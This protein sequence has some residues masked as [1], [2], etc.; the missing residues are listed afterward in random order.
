MDANGGAIPYGEGKEAVTTGRGTPKSQAEA[1]RIAADVL[2]SA[3]ETNAGT[4][5]NH[6]ADAL[7]EPHAG[8]WTCSVHLSFGL[9]WNVPK[10]GSVSLAR[11]PVNSYVKVLRQSRTHLGLITK[12]R[13]TRSGWRYDLIDDDGIELWNIPEN[14]VHTLEPYRY[15]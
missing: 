9:Q 12:A 5:L 3:G 11:Y 4:T 10:D 15:G 14:S 8:E 2:H 1:Y 13:Y 7:D 6:I